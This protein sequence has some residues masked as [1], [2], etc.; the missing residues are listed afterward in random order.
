MTTTPTKY[1]WTTKVPDNIYSFNIM[2]GDSLYE[3]NN[4]YMG[5]PQLEMGN[6]ATDW[7]PAPEDLEEDISEAKNTA[8]AAQG[9][10]KTAQQTADSAIDQIGVANKLIEGLDKS[11]ADLSKKI[12][13]NQSNSIKE[14]Y[15]RYY[16]VQCPWTSIATNSDYKKDIVYYQKSG[17]TYT[18][19]RPEVLNGKVQTANLYVKGDPIAPTGEETTGWERSRFP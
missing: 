5:Q 15:L 2:I 14:V 13:D 19:I 12:N 6:V 16:E 17:T 7:S 1:S 11:Q 9:E 4:I 3:L 18:K 10:A 8:D